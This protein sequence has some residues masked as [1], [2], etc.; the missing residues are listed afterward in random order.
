[1]A[2][3]DDRKPTSEE[4]AAL[5]LYHQ[6]VNLSP[7]DGDRAL[8]LTLRLPNGRYVGDVWLSTPDVEQ[9][10]DGSLTIAQH[11]IA[12][13]Y[14]ELAADPLMRDEDDV[15]PWP[16]LKQDEIT[17]ELVDVLAAEFEEFLKSEG[18]RA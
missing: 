6:L 12:Y 1:M 13:G 18:G 4:L 2:D 14:P 3:N 10:I 17:D 15:D 16:P 11:R 9:L 8:L 5:E 7:D